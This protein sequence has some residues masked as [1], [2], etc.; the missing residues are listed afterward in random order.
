MPAEERL[1]DDM[2]DLA[3]RNGFELSHMRWHSDVREMA[4]RLGLGDAAAGPANAREKSA[5]RPIEVPPSTG[6]H[7]DTPAAAA[8]APSWLTRRCTLGVAAAAVAATGAAIA[9]PSILRLAAKPPKPTLRTETFDFATLDEK[10]ARLATQSNTASAF[11]ET[12]G[13]EVSLEMVSIPGGAFTMGSPVYEPER[14]PNEGPQHQVTLKP[15]FIGASPV[16]QAQWAAVVT[17]RPARLSHGLDPFRRPS[18]PETCQS[19]PSAG[20]RRMSSA[21]GS[22]R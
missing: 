18:K 7:S 21:A 8:Q 3:F 13:S 14:R 16:T 12:L 17:A 9:L 11:A 20:T 1:P 15:F 10:G 4:Q 2:K 22:P 5:V 19:R 6:A